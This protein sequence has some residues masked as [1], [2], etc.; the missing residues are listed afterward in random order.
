MD[1]HQLRHVLFLDVLHCHIWLHAGQMGLSCYFYSRLSFH[2]TFVQLPTPSLSSFSPLIALHMYLG[3][4]M[5]IQNHTSR[6][7]TEGERTFFLKILYYGLFAIFLQPPPLPF[8]FLMNLQLL[9]CPTLSPGWRTA[10]LLQSAETTV[11]KIT[12]QTSCS[13]PAFGP[14]LWRDPQWQHFIFSFNTLYA[15]ACL[16]HALILVLP[17][18]SYFLLY[19]TW[20]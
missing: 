1:T 11:A 10:W 7:V 13:G 19:A 15:L 3:I 4:T 5:N 2:R 16:I 20:Q 14:F 12:D 8:F 18:C 17:A 6:P 9:L